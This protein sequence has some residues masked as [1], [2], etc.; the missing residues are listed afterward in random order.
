LL[1]LL[2]DRTEERELATEILDCAL[3]GAALTQRLLAFA[4]RQPLQPAVI[5]L[6]E[7]VPVHVSLLQRTLGETVTVEVALGRELWLTHADPSQI[8]DVLLNLAINARDAMPHGGRLK[9]ETANAA[10]DA[11]YC[12]RHREATPGEYVALSVA[13]TGTGMT[14]EVLAR[15]MEPFFT[16]KPPGKGSGLGLSTIYGFARQSGG[17]LSIDSKPGEGTTVRLY[18]PRTLANRTSPAARQVRMPPLPRGSE[19]I[20]VVDD[21]DSM[22]ATAARNLAALGYRV[23]LAADGPAALAVLRAGE[24]FGL[25][26]TDLVMPNGLSGYQLADAAHALQPGLPVLFTTGFAPDDD[27]G[28]GVMDANALRKPY[29]RRELAERVRTMLDQRAV[30]G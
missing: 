8:V 22:R 18:L 27:G 26:F 3:N 9:I 7:Y 30:S 17:Y 12:L 21:N 2:A 14:A 15:A 25:L 13:D 4:R 11:V 28:S 6:N 10:L 16:T 24:R 19:A 20:L 5:D 23:R 1:D 29:R